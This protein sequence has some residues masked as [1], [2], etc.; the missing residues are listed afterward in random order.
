M[1]P[2]SLTFPHTDDFVLAH[3]R[4]PLCLATAGALP[5]AGEGLGACDLLVQGGRIAAM[6]A[7][8]TLGATAPVVD[9]DQGIVLPRLV[10]LHTHLDKGHIWSRR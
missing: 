3:A 6:A 7:P 1:P 10:D 2:H 8:G 4:V 9:C 5:P